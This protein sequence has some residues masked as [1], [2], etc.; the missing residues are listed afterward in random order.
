[1]KG[2]D[3]KYSDDKSALKLRERRKFHK[4]RHIVIFEYYCL[5]NQVKAVQMVR[6]CITKTMLCGHFRESNSR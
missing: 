2:K 1:M 5:G 3:I 4:E 6:M